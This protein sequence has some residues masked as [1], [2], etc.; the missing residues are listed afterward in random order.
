VRT[1]CTVSRRPRRAARA[2]ATAP[3]PSLTLTLRSGRAN[4]G[5][6]A[7]KTNT[8]RSTRS[9]F[10]CARGG[11]PAPAAG[12]SG[13]GQNPSRP[14]VTAGQPHPSS[15]LV[16]VH[17]KTT[18]TEPARTRRWQLSEAGTR[19]TQD[20]TLNRQIVQQRKT[21]GAVNKLLTANVQNR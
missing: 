20:L 21:P 8:G 5:R 10:T 1:F 6:L 19:M 15:G 18:L 11:V 7:R 13:A 3:R 4:A 9:K 2:A 17:A 14:S 16:N 12:L